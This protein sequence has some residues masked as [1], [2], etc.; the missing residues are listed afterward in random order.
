[1]SGV[2]KALIGEQ[3]QRLKKLKGKAFVAAVNDILS[4]KKIASYTPGKGQKPR[5]AGK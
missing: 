1:M 3:A 2:K 5:K 4:P